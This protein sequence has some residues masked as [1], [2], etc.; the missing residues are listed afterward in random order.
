MPRWL[1]N[2]RIL[3]MLAAVLAILAVALWPDS[4][5]VD[6]A[7]A[8]R[9]PLQVTIDEEGET[10]VRERFAVSAPVAGRLRRIELEPGDPVERGGTVLASLTPVQPTLL[11]A[12]AQAELTAA[13]EAARAAVGQTQADRQ[14]A[15]AELDRARSLLRRQEALAEAGAISRDELEATQTALTTAEEA[16]RAAEFGVNRAEYDL[17]IARARLQQPAA[18]GRAIEIVSPIDGIVLRRIRES[19]AV[20]QA[21]EP[22]IEV[23]DPGQLEVVADLLSTDA[24][25]V[26]PNAR[27]LIE[28]WGGGHALEGR[29][30]RVEP[31]GFTKISALGVE[32]QRV[33]VI[34]DFAD[35]ATAANSL[36]DAYRVEVRIVAWEEP[37]VL[38]VPVGGLFRRGDAWAVFRIDAGRART[39]PVEIGQRNSTEAQVTG[40]LD[41]GQPIVLHPPDTLRD[42]VRVIERPAP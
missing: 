11:D 33:N 15:V 23:G 37:D 2:W 4:V 21:G 9:G 30:R 7:R 42:G 38:K 13:V 32:E 34:V 41:A 27:V 5:E 17:Q 39:Q 20:V 26:P 29:V 40:G 28:Q 1:T 8:V 22:L 16:R 36:G 31:S 18:G 19:E 35:P 3:A 14:R 10:R 12:R 25:R 24:V 6:I